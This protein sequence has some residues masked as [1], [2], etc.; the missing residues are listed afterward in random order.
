MLQKEQLYAAVGGNVADLAARLPLFIDEAVKAHLEGR[1]EDLDG[2]VDGFNNAV[3]DL[4]DHIGGALQYLRMLADTRFASV[5]TLAEKQRQNAYYIG[6]AERIG[7]ALKGLQTGGLMDRIDERARR[8]AAP[9]GL[10]RPD[11]GAPAPVAGVPARHH[12]DPQGL[13]LSPA[14]GGAGGAAPARL[15]PVPQTQPG[16]C[17]AGP[18]HPRGASRVCQPGRTPARPRPPRPGRGGHPGGPDRG[19]G[20]VAAEPHGDQARA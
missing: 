2:Y 12:R 4:A 13:S 18:R 14:G 17:R 7:E 16:L 1:T 3:F 6:R 10:S 20:Q 19:R 8:R 15:Q 9:A 11:L 5:R